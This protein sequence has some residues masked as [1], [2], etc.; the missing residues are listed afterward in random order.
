VVNGVGSG[1]GVLDG[2]HVPQG[3]GEVLM[4]VCK[5]G[6]CPLSPAREMHSVRVKKFDKISIWP[7]Y[8]W[9]RLFVG[10]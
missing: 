3:E 5:Y 8:H 2:V 1:T 10:F 6:I 4:S 9:K 7:K